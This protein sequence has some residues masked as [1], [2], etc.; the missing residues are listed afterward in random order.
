MGS[1]H[2]PAKADKHA[3][4]TE[5]LTHFCASEAK[6]LTRPVGNGEV[7]MRDLPQEKPRTAGARTAGG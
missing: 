4:L 3:K 6:G 1:I 2:N 7:L 5:R